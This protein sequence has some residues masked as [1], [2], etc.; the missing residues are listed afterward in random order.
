VQTDPGTRHESVSGVVVAD[1][2]VD[3]VT[4][5]RTHHDACKVEH[6]LTV[7]EYPVQLGITCEQTAR[8]S[9]SLPPISTALVTPVRSTAA[10]PTTTATASAAWLIVNRRSIA[11]VRASNDHDQQTSPPSVRTADRD[12][13]ARSVSKPHKL[14]KDQASPED[15]ASRSKSIMDV[16]LT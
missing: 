4:K 5:D 13:V 11:F 1:H 6:V 15:P 10:G 7:R 14:E 8:C 12:P 9:A 2:Q 3:V 16:A